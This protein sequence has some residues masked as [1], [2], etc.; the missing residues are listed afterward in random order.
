MRMLLLGSPLAED[1]HTIPDLTL[2]VRILAP[3]F[4]RT[5]R[6]CWWLGSDAPFMEF[7][8]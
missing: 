6:M 8:L 7:N 1:V 3:K 4:P 2:Q 5:S